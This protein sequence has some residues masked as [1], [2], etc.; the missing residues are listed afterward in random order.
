MNVQSI[1]RCDQLA[2]AVVHV[3]SVPYTNHHRADKIT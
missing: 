3:A 1:S 2:I